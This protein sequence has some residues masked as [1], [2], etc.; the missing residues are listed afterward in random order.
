MRGTDLSEN[1]LHSGSNSNSRNTAAANESTLRRSR[2]QLEHKGHGCI[3][4]EL[5]HGVDDDDGPLHQDDTLQNKKNQLL[6]PPTLE[7]II[8]CWFCD[9]VH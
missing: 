5:D 6:I 3:H 2:R 1:K 9:L 8:S 7:T 4:R